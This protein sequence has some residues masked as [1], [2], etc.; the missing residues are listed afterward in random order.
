MLRE[1]TVKNGKLR[2]LPGTNPRISVFK[3]IPY[4]APPVGRNRWRAPQPCSDWEGV[5]DCFRY[6]PISVQDQ[7]GV[8][9]DIYCREWHVDPDIPMDEDCLYLNIWTPA[10][11]TDEK[12]PVLVWYFGGAFQ[13]GYTAEMEFDGEALAKRGIIV[14][15][16]NYRLAL[17][18]FLCHPE[19]TAEAPD[20]PANFGLLDQKAGLHWVRENIAAFGGDPD[21]ITIAGQSAGG[22]SV[23]QQLTC[24]ANR[25]IVKGAVVLSGM[26]R[27]D[28]ES[29]D[30]FN[31]IDLKEA[32]RR[33]QEFFDFIG[34]KSL[35]EAR[36]ID[37]FK[38]RDLYGK[39]SE[40]TAEDPMAGMAKKMFPINDGI[41]F[42]GDPLLRLSDGECPDVPVITGYTG[43]EFTFNGINAVETS[44]KDAVSDAIIN[45][46]VK[47]YCR[48]F[49]TYCFD[50]D[51][52]G[53]DDPGTFHSV[54]LWF[55]FN[56]LP[57]CWRPMRGRHYDLARIMSG[58][59]VNFVK[60]HDPNGKDDDDMTD[61]PL[62]TPTTD[63]KDNFAEFKTQ[64]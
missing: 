1:V 62:W 17:M 61:L 52:P 63:G 43:D 9:T 12:L 57:K 41:S 33:G 53:W 35:E 56:N 42:P 55:W 45:D 59:L 60:T 49:F 22:A 40:G 44:V 7:P 30:I 29:A 24:P 25:D 10:N 5:K 51:I 39:Y 58:Y 8:G 26:I 37:A 27:I 4:A 50:P 48:K 11:K 18:G 28:N 38:L 47:S 14:V 34:V 19:I 16:V 20:A 54:D 15:S 23:M 2:G 21:N 3:G 46:K 6:A 13:W 64:A 32:E 36:A 31:P